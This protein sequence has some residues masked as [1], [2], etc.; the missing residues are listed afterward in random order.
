MARPDGDILDI[1]TTRRSVRKYMQKNVP[2][3]YIEKIMEAARWAPSAVN[4]QPW[5]FVVVRDDETRKKIGEYARFYFLINRHVSEAPVIIAVCSKDKSY[6]WAPLDCAMASQ[7]IM[8]EAHS[9]GLG[10]CFIGVF[11]ENKIKELLGLP[12][13]MGIVGLITLGYPDGKV[14]APP[15]LELEEVVHYDAYRKDK[16]DASG[17]TILPRSGM[18]S[19][20]TKFLK[21]K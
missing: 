21:G 10:S 6:R 16:S 19:F 18:L 5:R 12:D 15:R 20:V 3:E 7:N 13:K 2:D 9:L 11:D 17:K 4:G 1:I 14:D 8:L